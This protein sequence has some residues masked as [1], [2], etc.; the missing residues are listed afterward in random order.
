MRCLIKFKTT[1]LCEKGREGSQTNA[2]SVPAA[3]IF[4]GSPFLVTTFYKFNSPGVILTKSVNM[5]NL[6]SGPGSV[7]Q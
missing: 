2:T 1:D 7:A 5:L 3:Y 4:I 6:F